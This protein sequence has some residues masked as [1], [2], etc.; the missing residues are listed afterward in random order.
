M[1]RIRDY[2]PR[3]VGL[4]WVRKEDYAAFLAICED[5]YGFPATW[6]E[7]VQFSEEAERSY[8]ANGLI[9]ERAYIDPETF[10][11]WCA[12]NGERVNSHGRMRFAASIAA[13]KH[14]RDAG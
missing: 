14:G 13:E 8:K 12:R 9:V 1:T 11:D 4:P 3:A 10:P 2:G 6:E 7:F 5:A